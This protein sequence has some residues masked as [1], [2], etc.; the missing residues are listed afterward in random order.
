VTE[1][2]FNFAAVHVIRALDGPAPSTVV[3]HLHPASS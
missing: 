3:T 2:N 1:E